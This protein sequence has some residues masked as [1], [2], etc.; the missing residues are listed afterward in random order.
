MVDRHNYFCKPLIII[1]HKPLFLLLFK[2]QWDYCSIFSIIRRLKT[3]SI[4]VT[5]ETKMP[6]GNSSKEQSLVV[7]MLPSNLFFW[8]R[9]KIVSMVLIF[10]INVVGL[11]YFKDITILNVTDNM[12]IVKLV[13]FRSQ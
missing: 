9:S 13:I 11:T 10:Q 5:P 8:N 1:C 3:V 6:F 4:S 2:I 7:T 12:A